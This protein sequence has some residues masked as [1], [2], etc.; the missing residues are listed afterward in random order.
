M[1]YLVKQDGPPKIALIRRVPD[2]QKTFILPVI[3]IGLDLAPIVTQK[4]DKN[5]LIRVP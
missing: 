5:L 3:I 4:E 1:Y 2:G